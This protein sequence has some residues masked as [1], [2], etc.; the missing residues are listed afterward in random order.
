AGRD[1]RWPEAVHVDGEV[2]R[3]LTGRRVDRDLREPR[4]RRYP[5]HAFVRA[6]VVEQRSGRGG[7]V[8][9][10]HPIPAGVGQERRERVSE[11]VDVRVDAIGG[12]L[13][14][15]EDAERHP[16]VRGGDRHVYRRAVADPLTTRLR[17]VRVEDGG[18]EDRA[19]VRVEGEDL[20]R[21]R[22]KTEDML[23]SPLHDLGTT[24][25]Q[26]GGVERTR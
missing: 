6:K 2:V 22:G 21:V 10:P 16:R 17:G 8:I 20:G 14:E 13:S 24:D 11:E 19:A 12:L 25:L 18:H 7:V 23:R 15:T 9:E 26:H 3:E 5:L 4:V 1:A